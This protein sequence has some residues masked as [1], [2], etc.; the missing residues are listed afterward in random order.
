MR[1]L[2]LPI[3]L[4]ALGA[5]GLLLFAALELAFLATNYSNL[6][7]LLLTF[8]AVLGALGACW[9]WH[10]SRGV[11]VEHVRLEAAA[12]DSRRDVAVRVCAPGRTR[13]DVSVALPLRG[14]GA[15]VAHADVL[16]GTATL[17]GALPPQPRG[18]QQL[19]HALVTSRFPFGFFVVT[20]RVPVCCDVVSYPSPAP[21]AGSAACAPDAGGGAGVS[22]QDRG[23]DLA[24]LRP[25]RA[26]DAVGDVHWK[27]TARR[28]EPVV[29]ERASARSPL[30]DVVVDRRSE[31]AAL[32]RALSQATALVL[33]A[34]SGAPV[35]LRSQ[36]L[37]LR[38]EAERGGVDQALRWLAAATPLPSDAPPPPRA[39]ARTTE[40]CS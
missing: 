13:F 24:G 6:F 4:S 7:F 36:G 38:V 5:K 32:E 39:H 29:K 23:A 17:P 11:R 8:S 34:R 37:D 16:V 20:R 15:E 10:N 14:G 28:G 31:P 25:F 30:V 26:G 12:A 19:D 3:R 22:T 1:A 33:A 18:V 2:R 21:A 9:A 35:R 40:R 27:A